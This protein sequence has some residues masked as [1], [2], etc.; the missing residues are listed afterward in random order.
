MDMNNQQH[1][2]NLHQEEQYMYYRDANLQHQTLTIISPAVIHGIRE[3]Q[4]LGY[5]HALTEAVAIGYLM[6]EEDTILILLGVPLNLGGD[7]QEHHYL[8]CIKVTWRQN[9]CI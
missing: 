8:R 7:S 1:F 9:N 4:H 3:A 5:Q 2:R 6:W